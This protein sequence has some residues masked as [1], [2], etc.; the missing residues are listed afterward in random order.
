MSH[1]TPETKFKLSTT[2]RALRDRLL[3]DLHN[4]LDSTYRLS[5]PLEKAGLAEEQRAKR[6]WLEQWL[7][8]QA[9]A[10]GK[11]KKEKA[12]VRER[13]R[14]AAEKLAAATFLNRIVAIKQMEAHGLIKPALVTGGW[15]SPGYR[16]LRDFATDLLKDETEGFG[17]LLQLLYDEL[18]L[19][20]PGLFGDVGIV[21]L[22]PIPPSTL[23]AVIEAL[24]APD[25]KEAWL[26]DTTLGWVYQYWNDP[27]REAVD[28]KI[29]DGGKIENHEIAAKTQIFTER[30]MVEWLLQNS[31]N[32]Q[33]L[34]ICEKNGWTLEAKSSGVLDALEER[35]EAWR[36]KR[37]AGEVSPEAMMPLETEEEHRW[38]YWVPSPVTNEA[39]A[40]APSSIRDLKMIDPAVGSGHFLIISFAL[41]V[42][43]YEEEARHRGEH[44]TRKQIAESIIENNLHGV[45]IDP[46]AVQIAAA[47]LLLKAKS[48]CNN[49]EP[50]VV[51]L[52]ASNL[53][54]AAL[55]KDDLA[56]VEL[57]RAVRE[58]TGIPE[59][60]TEQIIQA[61]KGADHLGS[62][63]KVDAAVDEAIRK[64]EEAVGIP[65][66]EQGNLF[67]GYSTRH[68][69][70]FDAV[71]ARV[72]I[73]KQL[74]KFLDRCTSGDD[75]GLRL[76]G[77]QLAA[78]VRFIRLV[79]E[80]EY[81]VVVANPPYQGVSN[82]VD[83]EY[84]EKTYP[85]SKADLYATFLERGLQLVRPDGLSAMI[86][87]RGWMFIKN[88]ESLR[89]YLLNQKDLRIIG[90][91]EL[92][93][94]EEIS[95]EVVTAAMTVFR[96]SKPSNDVTVAL[97]VTQLGD[98]STKNN[99]IMK[100]K[101]SLLIGYKQYNFHPNKL[102][103]IE[104]QPLIYWWYGAFLKRY[105]ETPKM[106]EKSPAKKGACTS[107][108]TRFIRKPW[109]VSYSLLMFLG[110]L[111]IG[112]K[113][114]APY[115]MG[116]QGKAWFEGLDSI[117]NWQSH[118]LEVKV[119]NGHLYK[120][121]TRSIQNQDVYFRLGVAFSTIGSAFS[122]RKHRYHSVIDTS[123]SSVYPSNTNSVCAL[124]NSSLGREIL[125][126]LNPTVN[127]KNGDVNRLPHFS[128][129][130]A[131]K[132]FA[133]LDQAFTEHEAAR[134]N[135]VEFKQ[136]EAS[137]WNYAQQ[138]AQQ[139]VDREAGAPLP[140]Y[141]PVYEEPPAT[142]F[143]SYAIGVALGRF[144]ANGEGILNEAPSD[145]LPNGVLYLSAHSEQDSLEHPTC[146]P[147]KDT[148]QQYGGQ[149]AKGTPLRT[150]LRLSFFK[151]VH[152]GMY[153][154]RP[155]YLPL[156]SA[157]KNF[158]ALV[159]IHRWTDNTL[160]TLLADYLMPELNQLQGA[161]SDLMQARNMDNTK[162]QA[163]AEKRYSKVQQLH[164][165]LK[166]FIDLV[167]QCAE[168][169]PLP[170]KAT[171]TRREVDARFQMDL[172]D[173]VM[174]N[175]AALWCLLEPQWSQPKKWWSELCNAQG[176]KDYDWAHL[177]ARYFPKRV[178]EKCQ[179]DPSLAVAHGVFW[180]YHPAKAYEWEL[181][182][183]DEIA[184]NFTIDEENS[185]AL[186][187][188]FEKEHP[189]LVKKLIE[190]EEK[191]RE[192]KRK[193]EDQDDYGPLFEEEA[194]H[195]VTM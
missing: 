1:L 71:E 118:G 23:R 29:A 15:Q 180:K 81:D 11:G 131:D 152:L 65:R 137:A 22:I 182:L 97:K 69:T 50:K 62:L 168:Q 66:I 49:A 181:R 155:I 21:G 170:A 33:W 107:D 82:L 183:Q 124:M 187:K 36:Q 9:R 110:S 51:N 75:L 89:K 12:Q 28:A 172:D 78:G 59:E 72:S 30:Y 185:N 10:E 5:I 8:E 122:A 102:V 35:R 104:S 63:L 67:E 86:T 144:G 193:K 3:T 143:V 55:P 54:L 47:A 77:E 100:K 58:A 37:E 32:Q 120:S 99:K 169:G 126:A 142:H 87:M 186:C 129:E 112:V 76:R 43:F 80:G 84:L 150:W 73:L 162:S 140:K 41:L 106:N 115:V 188:T 167:R 184:P 4:G 98:N 56:V 141:Q 39:V 136:P 139:A 177:A 154:N 88:Y 13:H 17:T 53:G 44:W 85:K 57:K 61:L 70:S 179:K 145:A 92:G 19:E 52:V 14:L 83:G 25:L 46:R 135:S 146:K 26:D 111:D 195:N 40:A 31:L 123:G 147:L 2:I 90:D 163:E 194:L 148:W 108:N 149:I 160:Q 117:V 48:Y 34:A 42:A 24:D 79:K 138:W 68:S 164:D 16:E 166:T 156:S 132:I 7:D 161:L 109:E 191:R 95:G 93:A 116:A 157:K 113:T 6:Q 105:G 153:E 60:L 127:F 27:E 171:D 178:D 121:F 176:K 91:L 74:D 158:V 133:K 130:S 173:G 192:R 96:N 128:I 175:S 159:S 18:A 64:H 174:I 189:D 134:E 45:D 125:S 119:F 190:A 101:A 151:D 94:F 114:W 38:K 103:V 165:E 20:L